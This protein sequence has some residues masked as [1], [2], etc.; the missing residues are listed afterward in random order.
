MKIIEARIIDETHLE[1]SQP[2][3]AKP[4]DIIH[5]SIPDQEED[6]SPWKEAGKQHLLDAYSDEDSI[7]DDV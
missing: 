4:G 6:E 2:I 7:Y 5:I 3:E 1:L